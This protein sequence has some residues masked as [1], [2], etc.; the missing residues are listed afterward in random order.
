MSD[1][2]DETHVWIMIDPWC[3]EILE[4]IHRCQIELD[5]Q[6]EGYLAGVDFHVL[7]RRAANRYKDGWR[8]RQL[9]SP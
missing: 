7:D 9:G 5:E 3:D 2:S 1:S 4:R 8:K 6:F